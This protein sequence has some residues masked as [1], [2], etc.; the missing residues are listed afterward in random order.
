MNEEAI[1]RVGPQCQKREPNTEAAES[2]ARTFFC[3]RGF[4]TCSR[5][6]QGSVLCI[7]LSCGGLEMDRLLFQRILPKYHRISCL[8][9]Y[10]ES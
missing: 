2:R 10:S 4:Q 5:Y 8:E 3:D 9:F 6:G 7:V 1:P